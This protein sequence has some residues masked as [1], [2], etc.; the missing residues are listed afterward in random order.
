MSHAAPVSSPTPAPKNSPIPRFRDEHR[1]LSNFW[2]VPGLVRLELNG[3]LLT[4]PTVEHVFQAAKTLDP[5]EQQLVLACASAA[6]AKRAGRQVTMRPDWDGMKLAVMAGL[7]A[8]KY[9]EPG[10]AQQLLAT[11]DAPIAEGNHW[12]DTFWGVCSCKKHAVT[13]PNGDITH[14]E[15]QNWLG[16][17]LMIQRSYLRLHL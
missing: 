10:L 9:S 16:R 8:S 13:S 1:F 11:G 5:V 15:G 4:G 14:G 12:C 2:N 7:Q 3:R 6:D 17:I